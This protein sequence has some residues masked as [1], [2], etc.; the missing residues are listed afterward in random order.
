MN[1]FLSFI[2]T[3]APPFLQQEAGAAYVGAM[4]FLWDL[5]ADGLRQAL[6]AP[7][8]NDGVVGPA[9]DGL[10]DFGEGDRRLTRYPQE[11]WET[12]R[13]RVA[14]IWTDAPTYG[15][16]IVSQLTAAAYPDAELIHHGD[17]ATLDTTDYWSEFWVKFPAGSH[18]VVSS[19]EQ[20]LETETGQFITTNAE[21]LTLEDTRTLRSV[22]AKHKP[23]HWICRRVLFQ[24]T[25]AVNA[26]MLDWTGENESGIV[27]D[28]LKVTDAGTFTQSTPSLRPDYTGGLMV[29]DG[30]KQLTSTDVALLAAFNASATTIGWYGSRDVSSAAL[31]AVFGFGDGATK[32]N[33]GYLNDK[34]SSERD[35]TTVQADD[36][37]DGSN[38][39]IVITFSGTTSAIYVDGVVVKSGTTSATTLSLTTAD[40]FAD[41]AGGDKSTASIERFAL[42][43]AAL[44]TTQIGMLSDWLTNG[45]G[46]P[47]WWPY[48]QV[49]G[50]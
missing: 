10:D 50:A 27:V 26:N 25:P 32:M 45:D 34:V 2:Q 37:I 8:V 14:S 44:S 30:T 9:Y 42:F 29:S 1:T 13:V 47:S 22:I 11:S 40:V 28:T 18:N 3:T 36:A 12:Y 20:V 33:C 5:Q 19:E 31:K 16:D 43:G 24:W 35:G 15:N 23:G 6:R 48:L 38:H 39:A 7:Y 41:G 17:F 46:D 49:H 4:A 21:G